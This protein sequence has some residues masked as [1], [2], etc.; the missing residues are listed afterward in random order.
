MSPVM[1][2]L[3][4]ADRRWLCSFIAED[5]K[6]PMEAQTDA[7]DLK[8][9]LAPVH[10]TSNFMLSNASTTFGLGKA[11]KRRDFIG[12]IGGAAV[13]WPCAAWAQQ[14][15]KLY[16]IAGLSGGTAAS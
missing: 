5:R 15:G 13:I 1:A 4:N 3:R 12:L 6:W 7:I 16:R 11:M 9:R 2:L 10:P 14:P 8:R